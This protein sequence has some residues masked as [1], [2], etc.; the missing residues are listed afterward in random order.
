MS[1]TENKGGKRGRKPNYEIAFNAEQNA[2]KTMCSGIFGALRRKNAL[3]LL[4]F[5]VIYEQ[6]IADFTG[7]SYEEV[8]NLKKGIKQ[9]TSVL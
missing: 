9:I 3:E 4:S 6:D 2:Y 7:L 5:N 8:M 1:D